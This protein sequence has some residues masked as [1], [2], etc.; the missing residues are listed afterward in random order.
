MLQRLYFLLGG[1]C[2]VSLELFVSMWRLKSPVCFI[3]LEKNSN[4]STKSIKSLSLSLQSIDNIHGSDSLSAGMLS[5]S[6]TITDYILQKDLQDTTGLLIDKTRDTLD[7][8]TTG[9]TTDSRLGNTLDIITKDLSVTLGTSL[10]KS[11]SSFSS[12]RHD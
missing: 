3:V 5:V 4:L 1:L 11:L 12:A 6:D 9:K 2:E 8:T 10:S 7:T